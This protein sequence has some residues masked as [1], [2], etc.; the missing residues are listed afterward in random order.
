MVSETTETSI[1]WT[2]DAVEGAIGY[3]VQASADQVFDDSDMIHPAAETTFTASDLEPGTTMSVRVAAAGALDGSLNSAWTTHIT[4]TSAVPPPLVIPVPSGFMAEGGDG[5]ITWS[6]DAVEGADG[7]AIQVSSD[8][9]FDDMDETTYTMETSHTVEDLGYSESRFARVASTAGE[10]DD[11]MM[12][13]WTTHMTGMS[14]AAAPLPPPSVTFSL[15]DGQSNFMVAD[16]DDDEGTAMAWI[17]PKTVVESDSTAIITPMFVEGANGVHVGASD[18]NMPFTYVGAEDNWEMLQSAVLDGGATFMVQRTTMGANQE[19]EPSN[20]VS[21]VTCGPFECVEGEDAPDLSIANSKACTAWDPMVE[22]QVGKVDNDVIA[23][24]DGEEADDGLNRND[25]I[26]LGIVTSSSLKMNVKSVF[27]GVAGG[28]NTSSTV[29]AASGSDKTLGMKAV[30]GVIRI[31]GDNL[32]TDAEEDD[33]VVCDNTYDAEDVSSKADRPVGCFRLIGPGAMDRDDAK[34]PDYLSGWSIELSPMDGDV[35]WGNVDWEDDPFEDLECGAADPIMVADHVDVCSMFEAE[36]DGATGRG[37]SPVVVF[38]A[39][40][41]VVMWRASTRAATGHEQMFKTLWFDDNLNNKIKNDTMLTRARPLPDGTT[42]ANAMHDLYDQNG[43]AGNLEVI[44]EYLT[45]SDGDLISAVGDLGKVDLL[46]DEDNPRT[47]DDETT[48]TL[49]ACGPNVSWT[50]TT[51][52]QIPTGCS[53][54]AAT[55]QTGRVKTNPDGNADNYVDAADSV[56]FSDFR[57]CGEDDGGDD[58]DGSEC[59][60]EWVH[61]VSIL[62]ADG[63]FGCSTTRDITVTCEWDADGGMAQGRNA[64]PEAADLDSA[65]T[66]TDNNR[67]NFLKCTAK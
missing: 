12:S 45:D 48:I 62:F 63:T 38:D 37:W 57:G 32:D 39:N 5:S 53:G 60:A 36:V 40:N 30:T 24:D 59:D 17:N 23:P 14:A 26:D 13:M 7:Y 58:A 18:D 50:A 29:E 2:W 64:L 22:I 19:M 9:M 65:A 43:N 46:S 47:A 33:Y 25:G 16:D 54:D 34:G 35:T 28:T 27:S 31:D 21:Y 49:E 10:G 61:D 56:V 44:W 52:A 51:A 41:R 42:A 66:N 4:A 8:E 1:T 6:W 3:A 67:A 55:V 11:M 20:D 15:P